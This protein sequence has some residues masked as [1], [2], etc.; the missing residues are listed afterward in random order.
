[1][2]SAEAT[3][4]TRPDHLRSLGRRAGTI[5]IVVVGIVVLGLGWSWH[6]RLGPR[7][8]EHWEAVARGRTYL[9]RNR[10]DLALQAVV[11]VKDEGPGAGEAMTVAG[12]AMARYGQF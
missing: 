1:M 3:G 9:A 4:N 8:S 5:A 2:S 6:T 12:V 11:D 10:P 7:A